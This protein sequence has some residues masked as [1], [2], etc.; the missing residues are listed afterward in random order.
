MIV[1]TKL[2]GKEFYLNCESIE[3]ILEN[4]DTVITLTTGK[5][6]LVRE[7]A[8]EIAKKVIAFKQASFTWPGLGGN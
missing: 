3:T 7:S 5:K 8:E 6:L 1:L 2:D 4:P